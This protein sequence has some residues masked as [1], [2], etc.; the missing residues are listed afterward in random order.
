MRKII[1]LLL[2]VVICFTIISTV[3]A[4]ET[5][6]IYY[7]GDAV[8]QIAKS[9]LN[10][11]NFYYNAGDLDF[12]GKGID[13]STFASLCLRGIQYKASPYVGKSFCTHAPNWEDH[14]DKRNKQEQIS[15][16]NADQ[17]MNVLK[18]KNPNYL[19][20]YKS[21]ITIQTNTDFYYHYMSYNGSSKRTVYY[22]AGNGGVSVPF[23]R[24]YQTDNN[25]NYFIRNAADIANFYYKNNLA[26]VIYKNP[27]TILR[28]IELNNNVLVT[29][30]EVTRTGEKP[31][32]KQ[33][34]S[35]DLVFWTY[36]NA[37]DSADLTKIKQHSRFLG[38]THVGIISV[39]NG[40]YYVYDATS[41]QDSPTVVRKTKF[42][43]EKSVVLILRPYFYN[44]IAIRTSSL[45]SSSITGAERKFK[46]MPPT[47]SFSYEA[48]KWA[49]Q[50]KITAGTSESTFSPQKTC[51][52]AEVLTFLWRM[53]GSPKVNN[54]V[55]FADVNKILIIMM[56]FAGLR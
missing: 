5:D 46:D 45:N 51:T 50:N 17:A 49:Y 25:G 53:A 3:H 10:A 56:R 32:T 37:N 39:K 9:Y 4:A 47:N 19:T 44:N 55:S 15:Y 31:D 27:P 16:N 8:V 24:E 54:S 18:Y 11:D 42:S 30:D 23:V 43:N 40:N 12:S 29:K 6:T 2:C 22:L 14:F 48:I 28:T 1:S 36:T 52:R 21:K 20:T 33:L 41:S 38:I 34:K 7:G 13:C 35:G 26:K